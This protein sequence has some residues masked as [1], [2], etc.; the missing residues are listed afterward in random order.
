[1]HP[2]VHRSYAAAIGYCFGGQC[3]LEMVRN[4]DSIQGAASFHGVL[5]ST[6]LKEPLN[7]GTG[8]FSFQPL[9]GKKENVS[10]CINTRI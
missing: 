3:V 2:V 4:G 10:I 9:P 7:F 1:M 6:P 8:R 5:Q